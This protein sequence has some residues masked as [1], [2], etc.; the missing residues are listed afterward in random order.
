MSPYRAAASAI[1]QILTTEFAD[2]GVV[3]E[4]DELHESL[5]YDGRRRVGIAPLNEAP[6]AGN[7][8]HWQTF[9]NIKWYNPW[10]KMV[11]NEQAVDPRIAGDYAARANAAI[12]RTTYSWNDDLWFFNVTNI[13]YPRDPTGNVTRFVMTVVASSANSGLRET[14]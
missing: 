3:P 14:V 4:H 13:A 1:E 2:L 12:M 9:V 11:N 7:N 10:D 6:Q 5:A 8:S